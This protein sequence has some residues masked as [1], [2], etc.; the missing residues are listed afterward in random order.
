MAKSV[1]ILAVR[2]ANKIESELG[3]QCDPTTFRGTYAG[4]NQKASG[5]WV[6]IMSEQNDIR[7]VGSCWPA[8]ECVK[9]NVKLSL[10][11]YGEIIPDDIWNG[12]ILG[13]KY[14]FNN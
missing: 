1:S 14:D 8:T 5:A 12:G 13:E 9:K 6:W 11:R 7:D 2:L 3:I 4:R 10:W